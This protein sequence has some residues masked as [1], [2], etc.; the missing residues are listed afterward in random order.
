[1]KCFE[2]G[3]HAQNADVD[4][5]DKLK[6]LISKVGGNTLALYCSNYGYNVHEYNDNST[7][8]YYSVAASPNSPEFD[9]FDCFY[10]APDR[11]L[12]SFDCSV[13]PTSGLFG[14][15]M[16][17]LCYCANTE[18]AA[19]QRLNLA[20]REYVRAW[21]DGSGPMA[22]EATGDDGEGSSSSGS[23]SFDSSSSST[24]NPFDHPSWVW[25]LYAFGFLLVV[26]CG[27][28]IYCSY[29]CK[30][31]KTRKIRK[32]IMAKEGEPQEVSPLLTG[33]ST[34]GSLPPIV[35]TVVAPPVYTTHTEIVT[36]PA[37]YIHAPP[38]YQAYDQQSFDGAFEA[39]TASA[40]TLQLPA[41]FAVTS[42][43]VA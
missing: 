2:S 14:N 11:P 32:N 12:E 34:T 7:G 23:S 19:T 6:A 27:L 25:M 10:S 18:E 37:E 33:E 3:L 17:R 40:A 36:M 30:V 43:P 22:K 41:G 16:Q 28:A 35:E 9:L 38:I 1:M 4:S 31:K 15:D 39:V 24:S 26:T 8:D 5:P 42:R 20:A 13:E 29:L 21:K